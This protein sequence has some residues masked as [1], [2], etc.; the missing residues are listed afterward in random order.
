MGELKDVP[1]PA[2]S[3]TNRAT[4]HWRGK[5]LKSKTP[6][7]GCFCAKR[8][9][10][11]ELMLRLRDHAYRPPRD[12][13]GNRDG[14]APAPPARAGAAGRRAAGHFGAQFGAGAFL[15]S[16]PFWS[17]LWPRLSAVHWACP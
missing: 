10:V 9:Q 12:G 15:G 6:S 7:G 4:S 11:F 17:V 14:L 8:S 13:E 1:A 3:S 2:L 16:S 5:T